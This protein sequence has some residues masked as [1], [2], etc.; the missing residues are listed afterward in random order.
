VPWGREKDEVIPV[1]ETLWVVTKGKEG[2]TSDFWKVDE[3][4]VKWGQ[5]PGPKSSLFP[6]SGNF[7][8]I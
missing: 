7:Y 3:N 6:G 1:A 4:G 5:D 8:V 2:R